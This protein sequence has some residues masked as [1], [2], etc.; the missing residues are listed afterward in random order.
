MLSRMS[1]VLCQL[2]CSH[3][4]QGAR[5]AAP[6]AAP[7]AAGAGK[8]AAAPAAPPAAAAKPQPQPARQAQA[9]ALDPKPAARP[10]APRVTAVGLAPLQLL[11]GAKF[12]LKAP[13]LAPRRSAPAPAEAA[14]GALRAAG[15][16]APAAV[17]PLGGAAL[18]SPPGSSAARSR[19]VAGD[20]R[21]PEAAAAA[22]LGS[23]LARGAA[24]R[25]ARAH[26]ASSSSEAT[27]APELSLPRHTGVPARPGAAPAGRESAGGAHA[28]R[29]NGLGRGPLGRGDPGRGDRAAARRT[30]AAADR[31]HNAAVL[32]GATGDEDFARRV[33]EEEA[34]QVCA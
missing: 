29:G 24:G 10:A 30:Q 33:A 3:D 12:G 5:T 7:G 17:R 18:S 2:T 23:V 14:G 16:D 13:D 32:A 28:G 21:G 22:G 15:A 4:V 11:S 34:A 19:L 31:A 8:S 1:T 6:A 27:R 26:H 25:P 20:G 9:Q